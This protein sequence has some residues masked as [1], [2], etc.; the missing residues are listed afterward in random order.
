PGSDVG[1]GVGAWGALSLPDAAWTSRVG[2]GR[3]Q[4]ASCRP[5]IEDALDRRL[6]RAVRA[7]GPG[8]GVCRGWVC[9]VSSW[10]RARALETRACARLGPRCRRTAPGSRNTTAD[11]RVPAQPPAARTDPR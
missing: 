11:A 5:A 10:L 7:H 3:I 1:V 6:V 8:G 2:T 9:A 4:A